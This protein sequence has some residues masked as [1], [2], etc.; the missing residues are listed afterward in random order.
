M[1]VTRG[2]SFEQSMMGWSPRCYIPSFVE[3]G[4]PV[5]EKKIFVGFLPYM[6]VA[7]ILVT[8]PASC[9]QIFISLYL[10]AF[11]RNLVQIG[12]IVSEKIRFE[13]LYVH[14]LRPRSRND[15][16]LQYSHT[17]IYLIRFLLLLTSRSLASIVSE[18]STVFTFSYR[19]A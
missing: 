17:F 5:P 8:G 15:L 19:K 13:F 4:P 10:K 2:A 9:H 6:G 14:D 12:T 1:K 18:K 7:A 16:D 11:I 3:I